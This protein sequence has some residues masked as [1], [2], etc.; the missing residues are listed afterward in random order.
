MIL[1]SFAAGILLVL[2]GWLLIGKRRS[3]E[4]KE[5]ARRHLLSSRGRMIEAEITDVHGSLIGY[6]Y[7]V[8]SVTYHVVQDLSPFQLFLP[9]DTSLLI[10]PALAK[11]SSANP[12]N[13]ILISEDWSGIRMARPAA[14]A[15]QK[16]A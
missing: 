9:K 6:S 4:E 8:N 15:K 10:G 1:L 13:S 16:G 3:P 2:A 11:Y 7:Q 12:A 14:L 5:R